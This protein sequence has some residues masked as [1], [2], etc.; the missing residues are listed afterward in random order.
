MV[1]TIGSFVLCWFCN[2]HGFRYFDGFAKLRDQRVVSSFLI[3]REMWPTFDKNP[4]RK[5][6]VWTH[7]K[8]SVVLYNKYQSHG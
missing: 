4:L 2:K 8:K 5:S 3:L 7:K 6:E 1:L